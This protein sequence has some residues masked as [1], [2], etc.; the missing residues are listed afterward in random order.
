MPTV[1]NK[2]ELEKAQA[3]QKSE[4]DQEIADLKAI[5]DTAHGRRFLWKLLGEARMFHPCFTGNSE[6]YY[7]LGK[8]DFGLKILRDCHI[9]DKNAYHKMFMENADF[10]NTTHPQ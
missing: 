7:L 9:A 4:R 2:Q 8:R 5:L 6:T 3:G 10:S 1:R